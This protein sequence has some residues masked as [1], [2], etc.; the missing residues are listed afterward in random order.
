M[1]TPMNLDELAQRL[2]ATT[3]F[4]LLA[5]PQRVAL[6]ARSLR[7]RAAAGELIADT[8]TGLQDHLILLDGELDAQRTWTT[9]QGEE[10]V[11]SWRVSV[12]AD[13]PGF[14]LL[15]AS[16]SRIRVSAATDSEYLLVG[17]DALDDLLHWNELAGHPGLLRQR[18]VFHG[19]PVDQ[20]EQVFARMS[21]RKAAAGETIVT[22]GEPGDSYYV[23]VSGEAEVFV[24]DPLTDETARVAVLRDGD[25]FGEESLLLEGNRT[26]TVRMTS[27]GS[28]L[29]LA[30]AD[31]DD[32]VKPRMV[33]FVDAP[34]AREMLRSGQATLIDCRYPMEFEES[35][36][37][38]ARLLPLQQLRRQGVF[39]LDP[40]LTY[41]VCC[42][43]GRRSSVAAFLLRERG[44]RALSLKGGLRHWPFEIDQSPL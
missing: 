23:I 27:P 36:I 35:R 15:T 14:A 5:P 32:L 26:A 43:S 38:G 18:R 2:G 10:A 25:A 39:D 21:E 8:V 29:V 9:A 28:L 7:R 4:S 22:Q 13:G 34:A 20:V 12:G 37:P 3:L 6:L 1:D 11:F 17:S 24:K 42:L 33:D 19:L 40:A 16:G 44:I 41:V 31:F 30:K